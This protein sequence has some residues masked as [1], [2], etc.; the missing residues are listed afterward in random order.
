MTQLEVDLKV[1]IGTQQIE[2]QKRIDEFIAKSEKKIKALVDAE[3]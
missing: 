3:T 1:K 2:S